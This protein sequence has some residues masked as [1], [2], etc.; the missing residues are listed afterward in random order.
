MSLKITAITV[1]LD[2]DLLPLSVL[3][4]KNGVR[5]RVFEE[6]GRQVLKVG[7]VEQADAVAQLYRAWR[8][9]EVDIAVKRNP[10]VTSGAAKASLKQHWVT[11]LLILLSIGGFLLIYLQAP[12]AWI[13][14]LTFSPFDLVAGRPVFDSMG[15]Q[16]W[17][18]ITPAFLHFGWLHIVFNSLWLWELGGRVERVMGPGNLLGLFLVTAIV[19]NSCQYVFGGPSIFGGMSGVVYALLGFSWAG[20]R[21]QPAWTFSPPKPV[22]LFMVGWLVVCLLGVTESVGFGAVANAAH[23]GGLLSGA[24]LGAAFGLLSRYNSPPA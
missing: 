12:L 11:L 16:Y 10:T 19:S 5:H 21:L 8:N 2:E 4:T 24:I 15:G 13:G 9:G 6:S 3:L 23:L 22:M 1:A 20:A 7:Q 18:L 14:M 17:R